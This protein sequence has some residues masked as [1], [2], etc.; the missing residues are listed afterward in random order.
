MRWRMQVDGVTKETGDMAEAETEE[1][2]EKE[3]K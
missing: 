1:T 3:M 2:K